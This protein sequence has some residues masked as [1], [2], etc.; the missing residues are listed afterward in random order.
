[1]RWSLLA[2]GL[3]SVL[4]TDAAAQ[5]VTDTR[6]AELAR[7]RREVETMNQELAL[8]NEDLRGQLKA[9]EAQKVEIEVQIRREE[10]RL[11]QIEGEAA[12]RKA[13]LEKFG[14]RGAE[15]GPAVHD[16]IAKIRGAVESGLPFHLTE[17]LQE[18]DDLDQQLSGGA[19][20]PEAATA[21]LWAFTEDE[22]RLARENGLDRQ[23]VTVDG[24]EV[25]AD[26]ARLG[27]VALYFRT[28]GGVVGTAVR[29]AEG[30]WKWQT[31]EGRDAQ[32]TVGTLFEKLAHGIR[33]GSFVLP[34]PGA[35][36]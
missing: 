32:K 13:E 7:L 23:V 36:P 20:T 11:A 16:S 34:N 28:D 4:A 12:A 8:A 22:L 15:L 27:M 25:L 17:R 31:L 14:T 18:L 6:A 24:A 26:V 2:L 9:V 3:A 5:E 19:V 29:T 1:M 33:S 21:R 30:A 10:L 35:T